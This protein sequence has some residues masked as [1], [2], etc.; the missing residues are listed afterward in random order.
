ME[1]RILKIDVDEIKSKLNSL[2][3][4]KVKD[5]N[6]VNNLYDFPDRR[7]LSKKGYARIRIVEDNLNNVIIN[8]MTTKKLLSQ[9][10]YKVMEENEIVI[11]NSSF[12]LRKT[13]GTVNV[14]K[15]KY[16]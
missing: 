8:Y 4:E 16:L 14:K 5:E 10:K 1:T 9:E 7:L 13:N 15:H 3:C 12:I 6:Q 2:G 11:D